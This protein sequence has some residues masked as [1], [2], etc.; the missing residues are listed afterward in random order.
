MNDCL[1]NFQI[2]VQK[3]APNLSERDIKDFFSKSQKLE[4][5]RGDLFVEEGTI[6]RHLL[7]IY[8]GLFRYYL[9]HEGHDFTKDFAVDTRN[10]FCTAYTSFM[11][12]Q[13]SAIWIE[14]LEPCQVWSWHQSDVLPLFHEHPDW[15]RFAK[16][17]IDHLFYRKEQKEIILLKYSAKERYRHF[18]IDFPELS[19]RVS[20]YHIATYLGITPE[21]LS[22]IRSSVV[23]DKTIIS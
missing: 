20:Q 21:S 15:L 5:Q 2:F 11:F 4:F 22:R 19:Q 10:P 17:M 23:K 3:I 18:L 8:R 9:L 7:F 12:Q 14:A 1:K 13:P 16:A 6:C